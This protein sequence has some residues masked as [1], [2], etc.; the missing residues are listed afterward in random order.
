MH[1]TI[2]LFVREVAEGT[3]T[4]SL[5][6]TLNI[7]YLRSLPMGVYYKECSDIVHLRIW[8]EID[9]SHHEHQLARHMDGRTY[10]AIII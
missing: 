3:M 1:F 5:F 4:R 2:G 8:P 6:F 10:V 7:E 9:Q